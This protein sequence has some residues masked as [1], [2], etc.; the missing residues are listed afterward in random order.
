[1]SALLA[2][3]PLIDN[4]LSGPAARS[5]LV[6]ARTVDYLGTALFVGGSAFLGVLWPAGTREPRARGVLAVG[7]VFGL[8]G[9][10][11]AILLQGAWIDG[12]PITDALHWDAAQRVLATGFGKVW[13]AKALLWVLAVVVMADLFARGER[14]AQSVAWRVGAVVVSLGLLRT[15]GLTGHAAERPD[16]WLLGIADLVHVTG[17][18]LWVGGLVMLL[19][20]LL[21]RRGPEELAF[22]VP[23]YSRLAFG[24]VTAIVAGGTVLALGLVGSWSNLVNTGYGQLLIL[25]IGIFAA[26]LV[27]AFASKTWVGRRLDV[28]V[29]L[30]GHAAAVR[31]FVYSVAMETV[32]VVFVLVAASFLVTANPGR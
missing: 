17:I 15:L 19:F 1:M 9:T 23:R 26:A 13:A 4:A 6:V 10:L 25:K 27:G 30:R 12:G 22:V 20:G 8:F 3:Q 28:A 21:P 7:V 16:A 18:S 5:W 24:S 14:A 11:V 32:L 2:A 29:T 31:P